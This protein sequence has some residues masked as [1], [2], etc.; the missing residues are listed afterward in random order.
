MYDLI[1]IGAGPAG[2]E[3]ALRARELNK[4]VLLVEKDKVGGTCL[5][6]GCV[7]TKS[8]LFQTNK[9][10]EISDLKRYGILV[11]N[12]AYDYNKFLSNKEN[13]VNRL[14]KGVS[15]LLKNSGVDLIY[16]IATLESSNSIRVDDKVYEG[17]NILIAT[18]ATNSKLPIEGF[19]K[20]LS[21]RKFLEKDL[22]NIKEVVI[23]GGGVI[24]VEL[25]TLLYHLKIKTTIVEAQEDILL[26]ID[27]DAVAFLK[28]DLKKNKVNIITNAKVNRIEENKVTYDEKEI[29]CDMV[30]VSV[31]RKPNISSLDINNLL[32]QENSFIKVDSNF[33]TN[34]NNVY[35]VGD[36][37]KGLQLAHYASACAINV[38]NKMFDEIPK[39]NLINVPRCVYC[40]KEISTVGSEEVS[41]DIVIKYDIVSNPKAVIENNNR[42]FYKLV[43]TSTG[44][45][46][47][48]TLVCTKSSDMINIFVEALNNNLSIID[49]QKDIYPHPSFVEGIKE[50]LSKYNK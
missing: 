21:S 10:L 49:M 8:L 37:V 41:D 19:N 11:E 24:G 38:V 25:A 39:Y 33:K 5:N 43:F 46:K 27:K 31:G 26:G 30:I 50:V 15:F 9:L 2:Y 48:A 6:Y 22:S 7:P 3:A 28:K 45:F 47:G 16:G 40:D 12:V 44:I 35:A 23:I 1:V 36:C 20:A 13:T 29:G 14:V 34:L 4:T 17:K 42:G 32:I 18:G